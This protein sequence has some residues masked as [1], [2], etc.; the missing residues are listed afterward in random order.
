[1]FN[2]KD[3]L[4]PIYSQD[5]TLDSYFTWCCTIQEKSHSWTLKPCIAVIV[6]SKVSLELYWQCGIRV[7]KRLQCSII[8]LDNQSNCWLHH[9][10]D[11]NLFRTTFFHLFWYILTI[12]CNC[13]LLTFKLAFILWKR[14]M[15]KKPEVSKRASKIWL[16][17]HM[18]LLLAWLIHL[19][20][21]SFR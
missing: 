10:L 16:V 7:R 8:A 13:I 15:Q 6:S 3:H 21:V 1:M 4:F 19:Q 11:P 9:T 5:F 17:L 18:F 12:D 14:I 2:N 20:F